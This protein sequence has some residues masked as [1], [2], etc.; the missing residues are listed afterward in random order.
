MFSSQLIYVVFFDT[1]P[2]MYV[3]ILKQC[4]FV[5]LGM[6]L[7]DPAIFW[8][9]AAPL[10]KG[11]AY[12]YVLYIIYIYNNNYYYTAFSQSHNHIDNYV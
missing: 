10:Q 5:P 11:H 8:S 7:E 6:K 9:S 1:L 4:I 12:I 3:S 2:A